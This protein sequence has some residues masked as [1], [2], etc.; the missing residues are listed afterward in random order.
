MPGLR[1][2]GSKNMTCIAQIRYLSTNIVNQ[3]L[4]D[5]VKACDPGLAGVCGQFRPRADSQ[6]EEAPLAPP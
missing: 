2:N 3:V 1:I 6:Q 4:E 5:T